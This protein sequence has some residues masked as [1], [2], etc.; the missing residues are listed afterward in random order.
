[1]SQ[2]TSTYSSKNELE[3]SAINEALVSMDDIFQELAE[4]IQ[5]QLRALQSVV[6][7]L[8]ERLRDLRQGS[9]SHQAL[10]T[11]IVESKSKL[12]SYF[13]NVSSGKEGKQGEDEI[14]SKNTKGCFFTKG[15]IEK[16]RE[17]WGDGDGDSD[18]EAIWG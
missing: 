8:E 2:P 16:S 1:M 9:N 6:L 7:R 15:R 5:T 4:N 12:E 10:R 11:E 14:G 18:E 3:T 13:K 17:I